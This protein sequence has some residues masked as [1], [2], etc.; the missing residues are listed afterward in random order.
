MKVTVNQEV[1][2]NQELVDKLNQILHIIP[3][4]DKQYF[5]EIGGYK[6]LC[7]NLS[8]DYRFELEDG[9]LTFYDEEGL[10]MG[11]VVGETV[12]VEFTV[13]ETIITNK[14]KTYFGE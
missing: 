14:T 8:L 6:F 5:L 12:E 2:V 3:E 7:G 13:T 9:L 4:P 10:I 1:A 11:I